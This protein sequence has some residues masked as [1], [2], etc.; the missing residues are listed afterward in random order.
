MDERERRLRRIFGPAAGAPQKEPPSSADTP[1]RLPVRLI[2]AAAVALLGLTVAGTFWLFTPR[3]HVASGC[4]WWTAKTVGETVPG[5]S[6][7]VRGYVVIGAGLAEASDQHAYRLS[8][9]LTEPDTE[10]SR[11]PCP[12]RPGDAVVIRQHAIFDDGRTVLII[13][14]CR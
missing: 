11:A 7:C 6:G 10:S 8:F 14:D 9:L 3:E 4:F 1:R 2:A 5:E 13:D 12:F